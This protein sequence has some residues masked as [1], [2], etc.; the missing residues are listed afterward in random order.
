MADQTIKLDSDSGSH[1]RV[2]LELFRYVRGMCDDAKKLEKTDEILNLYK[3]CRA[4][5]F[6]NPA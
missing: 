5:T 4:A 1:E 6:L 2:A 3:K